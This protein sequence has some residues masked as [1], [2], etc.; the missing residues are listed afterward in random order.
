MTIKQTYAL[1]ENL[2]ESK[3]NDL[4][5]LAGIH[6]IDLKSKLKP[7]SDRK[8]NALFFGDSDSYADLSEKEKEDLTKKMIGKHK[9]WVKGGLLKK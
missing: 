7:Q 6:G 9:N 2:Q 4:I 3:T 5:F 8:D 1:F